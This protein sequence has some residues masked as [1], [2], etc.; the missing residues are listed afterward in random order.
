[1]SCYMPPPPRRPLALFAA[2]THPVIYLCLL[3]TEVEQRHMHPPVESCVAECL[4]CRWALLVSTV[5][6]LDPN[7][8]G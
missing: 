8:V 1:M 2:C 6:R 4:L 3:S 7:K 5:H